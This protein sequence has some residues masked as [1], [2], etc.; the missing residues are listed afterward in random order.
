MKFIKSK[1]KNSF[2]CTLNLI[3]FKDIFN[4]ALIFSKTY[5]HMEEKVR[6]NKVQTFFFNLK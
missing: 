2:T 3:I 4:T 5:I 1:E 6:K